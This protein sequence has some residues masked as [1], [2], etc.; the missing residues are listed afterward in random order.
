MSDGGDMVVIVIAVIV[1]VMQLLQINGNQII[2]SQMGS[3]FK[4]LFCVCH[5]LSKTD[6][7]TRFTHVR[8][9]V[10]DAF[11]GGV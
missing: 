3:F 10:C 7:L 1:F 11:H 9:T 2:Y 4:I 6:S 5:I 8:S